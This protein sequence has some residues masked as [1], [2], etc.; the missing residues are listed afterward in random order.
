VGP[1]GREDFLALVDA[2]AD[3]VVAKLG[4]VTTPQSMSQPAAWK[5]IGVSRSAWFRLKSAGLLPKPIALAG[6]GDR[7]RR[8]DLDAWLDRMKPRR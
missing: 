4:T 2:V 6:A 8:K 7:W 5:Y 3:A 1:L